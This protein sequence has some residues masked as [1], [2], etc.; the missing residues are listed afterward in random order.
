MLSGTP[1]PAAVEDVLYR[2][3][4]EALSNATRHAGARTVHVS[5]VEGRRRVTL[6]VTDDGGGFDPAVR[7]GS[8][9]GLVGMRERVRSIGGEV[10]IESE[11]GRGT[12]VRVE[13]PLVPSDEPGAALEGGAAGPNPLAPFPR[14]SGPDGLPARKGNLP[15]RRRW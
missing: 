12:T 14:P 15:R 7:T 13:L 9:F 1:L 3:A 10:W 6:S 5:V 8:G 4:Q 11:R 2:A